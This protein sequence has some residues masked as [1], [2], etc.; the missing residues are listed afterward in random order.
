MSSRPEASRNAPEREL[1]STRHEKKGWE[2]SA[3]IW[4]QAS[5]Q[6]SPQGGLRGLTSFPRLLRPASAIAASQSQTQPARTGERR[7][8]RVPLAHGPRTGFKD[9][10]DRAGLAL[11]DSRRSLKVLRPTNNLSPRRK[12]Q[13][14]R[15]L[16]GIAAV[17]TEEG[18]AG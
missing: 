15:R 3:E 17:Q 8:S 12:L 16:D 14:E 10:W 18:A 7:T 9:L 5:R 11:R 13:L 2:G 6:R 1:H 4:D